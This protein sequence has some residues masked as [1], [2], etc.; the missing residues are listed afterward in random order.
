MPKENTHLWFAQR[1]MT[2]LQNGDLPHPSANLVLNQPRMFSLGSIIP[3]A[4]FYH[5]RA[6]GR[7][8]AKVLHG[9]DPVM[10]AEAFSFMVVQAGEDA[11][12]RDQAFVLGYLSHVA[13]DATFHPVI[14]ALSGRR[15]GRPSSGVTRSLHRLLETGLDRLVNRTSRYPD[16]IAPFLAD[17]AEVLHI[18]AGHA[19]L[20]LGD[21]R[22]ALSN[23][24]LV[25]RLAQ[26]RFAHKLLSFFHWPPAL[27]LSELR[28]LCY[29]QL[30]EEDGFDPDKAAAAPTVWTAFHKVN[31]DRLFERAENL[32]LK[33]FCLCSEHWTKRLDFAEL[34]QA[35]PQKA[36]D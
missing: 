7:R 3:D 12:G 27:D 11:S 32:A 21:V 31:W 16:I 25:S 33:L 5:Y 9:S 13:L 26:G 35:F 28:N 19:G 15:P 1:L 6:R 8:M 18:L 17:R 4:F 22:G 24:L 30:D 23:Q 36:C 29:A 10:R 14:H 20:R 34:R 2:R